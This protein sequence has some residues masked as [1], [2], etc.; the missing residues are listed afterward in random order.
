MNSARPTVA[1]VMSTYNGADFLVEQIDSVLG[2]RDVEVRLF[3]RDDGSTD[4]TISV[5]EGYERSGGLVLERGENVGVV[6]S[7]LR[8]L[9]MV[10][11][12]VEFIA[13]CDQDDIWHADKLSRAVDALSQGDRSVPRLYCSEYVFC[14]VDMRP[15]EKSHLNLIGV[16]FETLLYETK[17]SGNTTVINRALADLALEAGPEGVYC[18]DWWLGL[19]AAGLGELIFDDYASLDY[20]R[21]GSTVSPTG[22]SLLVLLR[23]RVEKFLRGGGLGRVADQLRRYRRCFGDDLSAEKRE[24]LD[25][26]LCGGRVHKAMAPVRLRQKLIEEIALRLLFLIGK[27]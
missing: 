25:F 17:V 8:A 1:V 12:S 15:V 20:R 10:P 3:V 13:L 21:T 6:P 24:L 11:T 7:F 26:F 2:Q 22:G 14:D 23:Y 5:L 4:G 19:I 27:L 9:S 18:H 16:G